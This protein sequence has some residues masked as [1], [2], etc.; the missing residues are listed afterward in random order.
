MCSGKLLAWKEITGYNVPLI[1]GQRWTD[2][3]TKAKNLKFDS[4]ALIAVVP[5]ALSSTASRRDGK[6]YAAL[7]WFSPQNIRKSELVKKGGV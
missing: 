2:V 7:L 3:D 5:Q 6:F 1:H 4:H